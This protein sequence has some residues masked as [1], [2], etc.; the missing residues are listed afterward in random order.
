MYV[1][2]QQKQ[3]KQTVSDISSIKA[4]KQSHYLQQGP[5]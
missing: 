4:N 2:F 5:S 1:Y 3:T